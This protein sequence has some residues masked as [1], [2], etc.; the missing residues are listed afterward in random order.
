MVDH[1]T[2]TVLGKDYTNIVCHAGVTVII[3]LM[4]NKQN[5]YKHVWGISR[6]SSQWGPSLDT[7]PIGFGGVNE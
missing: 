3:A 5:V 2:E 7:R 1:V 4:M 6:G